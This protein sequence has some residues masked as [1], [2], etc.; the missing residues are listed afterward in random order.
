MPTAPSRSAAVI[1]C[2][3]H[4]TPPPKTQAQQRREAIRA[5]LETLGSRQDLTA[6]RVAVSLPDMKVLGRYFCLPPMDPSRIETVVRFQVKQQ[7]PFPESELIWDYHAFLPNLDGN[8]HSLDGD[9]AADLQPRVFLTAVKQRQVEI[10]L[11]TFRE[12]GIKVDIL[13]GPATALHNL[14]THQLLEDRQPIAI[15]DVGHEATNLV[16][17]LCAHDLVSQL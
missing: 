12:L 14:A 3:C 7:I 2:H 4:S 17:Q 9:G 1:W 15:V 16:I 8:S 10:A 13:Q 6:D 5:A 11:A